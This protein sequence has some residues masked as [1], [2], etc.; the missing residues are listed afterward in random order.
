[1]SGIGVVANNSLLES[2]SGGRIP[3]LLCLS[4]SNMSTAGNWLSPEGRNLDAIQSD[5]FEV[6]FG[7]SSNPGQLL[8][9]TPLRNPPLSMTH[10]G[11]YTCAMPDE[12][13]ELQALHIGIYLSAGKNKPHLFAQCIYACTVGVPS[14]TSLEL[15]N[16]SVFT[17]NCTSSVS[18]ASSVIWTRNNQVLTGYDEYQILRDGAASLYDNLLAIDNAADDLLGTYSCSIANSAGQS[19]VGSVTFQGML[20]VHCMVINLIRTVEGSGVSKV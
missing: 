18:P 7:G 4:A 12:E 20:L 15:A 14:V 6:M 19:N 17:L 16:S 3:R 8:V 2:N 9:E 5:P 13:N 1:M 11:V 10:E